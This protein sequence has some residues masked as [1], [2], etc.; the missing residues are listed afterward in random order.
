[1][2]NTP[3]TPV[4]P[5]ESA[6]REVQQP[7]PREPGSESLTDRFREW[8][9]ALNMDGEAIAKGAVCALLI[10]FFS[11][12]QTTLFTRFRPFGAVPDLILPLIIAI[13]MTEREKWGAVCGLVG[14]FVIESLGGSP[15]TLLPLLYMPA[16]YVC[17]L[18]TVHNFRDSAAVRALYTAVSSAGRAVFTLIAVI[19]T[20]GDLPLTDALTRTVLPEFAANLLFAA[21]PH[22]AAWL[23]LR[24]FNKSR[25][26]KVQ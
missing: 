2:N 11:L 13:S 7:S 25:D 23:A 26:A 9:L 14:A 17:G 24:P 20:V 6:D 4:R 5:R 12:V 21:L 1:M 16:G 3:R 18:L 10:N 19:L 22:A 15:L 8:R